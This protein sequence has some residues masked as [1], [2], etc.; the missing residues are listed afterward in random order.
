MNQHA[1]WH[2]L[3]V[4]D[5]QIHEGRGGRAETRWHCEPSHT[6]GKFDGFQLTVAC[7]QVSPAVARLRDLPPAPWP[8]V[9][10]LSAARGSTRRRV[11]IFTRTLCHRGHACALHS[12]QLM[13]PGERATH[14]PAPRCVHG[15][16]SINA[17]DLGPFQKG[18]PKNTL[19]ICRR[20]HT[21]DR[22][23]PYT[24]SDAGKTR[25]RLRGSKHGP[26]FGGGDE[27]DA[28]VGFFSLQV[29][30]HCK[31]KGPKTH[32]YGALFN[33]ARTQQVRRIHADQL[34]WA[35]TPVIARLK[36]WN[37]APWPR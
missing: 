6:Q 10:R 32:L 28:Y 29:F 1:Q 35:N 2:S 36:A 3:R 34:L 18:A 15:I 19:S 5:P 24:P 20:T 16:V 9:H 37:A 23:Q 26:M 14:N 22:A 12:L 27:V 4:V 21:V 31:E 13:V 7:R 25:Q 8:E 30:F 33:A 17:S 11:R